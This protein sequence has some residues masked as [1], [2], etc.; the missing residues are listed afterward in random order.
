MSLLLA[1]C[2]WTRHVAAGLALAIV[3]DLAVQRRWKEAILVAVMTGALIA[4]WVAWLLK[5]GSAGLTQASL[6]AQSNESWAGRVGLLAAFYVERIPDQIVGPFVEVATRFQGSQWIAISA[7]TWAVLATGLIVSGW[8]RALRRPRRRL[9]GLVPLVTLGVLL[10]WPFTEAGRFLIPL[11]PFILVGA[12]EGLAGLLGLL[13][14]WRRV[15]IRA[16]RLRLFGACLVLALSLPYSLYMLATGRTRAA[17]ASQGDFD[18]ACRWIAVLAARAGPVVSRH[19]GEVFLRTGRQGL[20]VSSSER[21]GDRDADPESID[22]I[23]KRY[24]V[25]YLLVDKERYADAP[26]AR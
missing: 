7:R 1:S 4:P 11:I 13:G 10:V 6:L 15:R 2:L 17:E 14:H 12:V 3:L 24:G 26:P 19:P 5:V 22:E 20:E 9:A 18:A 21:P 8:L 23:I 25:A 16:T